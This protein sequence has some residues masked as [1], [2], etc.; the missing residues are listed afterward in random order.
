MAGCVRR[1]RDGFLVLALA[2]GGCAT[3]GVDAPVN[4][5]TTL[6]AK[7]EQARAL[8]TSGHGDAALS[9][10]DEAL[11]LEARWGVTP[12]G[13]L[14]ALRDAEIAG[15]GETIDADIRGQLDGG[16][17]LA[18]QKRVAVLEPLVQQP[19]LR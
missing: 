12:E 17:P 18:A 11:K 9:V 2:A 8:R 15:A 13:D 1:A 3:T 7:L 6:R 5:E 16:A 4:H 19:P 14:R 10:L